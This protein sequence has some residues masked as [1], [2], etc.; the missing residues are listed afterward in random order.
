MD[1]I[2]L[3]FHSHDTCTLHASFRKQLQFMPDGS[4][5]LR[6]VIFFTSFITKSAVNQ[7][8]PILYQDAIE[9]SFQRVLEA[10]GVLIDEE[11]RELYDRIRDHMVRHSLPSI[12]HLPWIDNLELIISMTLVEAIK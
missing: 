9:K 8:D 6:S 3:T 12:F 4:G 11:I 7:S 2:D 10:Y 1:R 5:S